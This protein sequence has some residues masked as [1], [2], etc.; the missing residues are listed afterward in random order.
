MSQFPR[1]QGDVLS[2]VMTSKQPPSAAGSPGDSSYVDLEFRLMLM[3]IY[4]TVMSLCQESKVGMKGCVRVL[5]IYSLKLTLS[6]F[7]P[8]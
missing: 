1:A 2:Q 4:F 7:Y 8:L 5:F 3:N 6:D